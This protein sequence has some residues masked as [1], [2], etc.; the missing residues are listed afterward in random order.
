MEMLLPLEKIYINSSTKF[1]FYR[2]FSNIVWD[3]PV[4]NNA[5]GL[6]VLIDLS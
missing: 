6:F 5:G 1:L 3:F 4:E 2:H